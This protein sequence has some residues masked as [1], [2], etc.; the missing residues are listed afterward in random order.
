MANYAPAAATDDEPGSRSRLFRTV[1]PEGHSRTVGRLAVLGLAASL[2]AMVS[3]GSYLLFP[4]SWH[5]RDLKLAW[6]SDRHTEARVAESPPSDGLPLDDASANGPQLGASADMGYVEMPEDDAPAVKL[7]LAPSQRNLTSTVLS[8]KTE[9]KSKSNDRFGG[10]VKYQAGDTGYSAPRGEPGDRSG[11]GKDG[12][13]NDDRPMFGQPAKGEAG[14]RHGAGEEKREG[15]GQPTKPQIQTKLPH[16]RPTGKERGVV[17]SLGQVE[18]AK[19]PFPADQPI[20]YPDKQVW[21]ELTARRM[22]WRDFNAQDTKSPEGRTG[23]ETQS[24]KTMVTPKIVIQEEEEDRLGIAGRDGNSATLPDGIEVQLPDFHAAE[25]YEPVTD[26]PFLA[27]SDNPLSTF[28]IDVDTASYS[29]VRRYLQQNHQLPPPSAVRIEELVNYFHYDYPQPEGDK[30]FAAN[31]EVAGC[32]WNAE[33]RLVRMGL[34][35]REVARDHRPLSKPGVSGRCV[36]FDA[37][38]QQAAAGQRVAKAAGRADGRERPRG[39]RGL[40]RQF[41]PGAA[42]HQRRPKSRPSWQRSTRLKPAARPTAARAFN[43]P[44]TSPWPISSKGAST[45]S[46]WPPTAISTSASP[47]AATWSS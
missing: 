6:K 38:A 35:G 18:T 30:P 32:P 40:C 2:L 23:K 9:T 15:Q 28:S 16:A 12:G 29:I 8:P 25:A 39:D 24:L 3:L 5:I 11:G 21:D 31:V 1:R 41:G 44:T 14:Q 47:T 45:A 27:V 33:H 36:G 13:R 26:N 19:A 37:I 46:S 22:K 17:D 34:K 7:Q 20:V 42:Q 10:E 43:W 4:G